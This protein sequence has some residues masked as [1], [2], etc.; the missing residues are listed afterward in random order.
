MKGIVLLVL[1]FL[2]GCIDYFSNSSSPMAII[3]S[4]KTIECSYKIKFENVSESISISSETDLK[5]SIAKNKVMVETTVLFIPVKVIEDYKGDYTEFTYEYFGQKSYKN[6]S[7]EKSVYL[8][9]ITEINSKKKVEDLDP[10]SQIRS[11]SNDSSLQNIEILDKRCYV[12][13]QN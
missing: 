3:E 1:F 9:L 2:A 6:E 11:F 13:S 12:K 7:I 10:L 5:I 4:G 8:K